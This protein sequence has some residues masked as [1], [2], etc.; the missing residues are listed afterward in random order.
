MRTLKR[1][2]VAVTV[3]LLAVGGYA[4]WYVYGA[5]PV[6][7][8]Y[9]FPRHSLW[10]G[11]PAALFV[12]KLVEVDGCLRTSGSDAATVVWPPGY[13]LDVTDGRPEVHG[14]GQVIHLGETVQLG[15][16][17]YEARTTFLPE[18]RCPAPFFLTTGLVE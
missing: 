10:G 8:G 1:L 2:A 11:G 5:W 6:P 9:E 16:G 3:V 4:L 7:A 14:S 12:G 15:G 13:S 17:W 18:T